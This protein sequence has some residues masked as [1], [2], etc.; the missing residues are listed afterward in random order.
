MTKGEKQ[1]ASIAVCD[2]WTMNMIYLQARRHERLLA[3]EKEESLYRSNDRVENITEKRRAFEYYNKV[4]KRL[5]YEV[6]DLDTDRDELLKGIRFEQ[7][8]NTANGGNNRRQRDVTAICYMIRDYLKERLGYDMGEILINAKI[9]EDR[10]YTCDI[11]FEKFRLA[12]EVN[13]TS[14]KGR[15]EYDNEKDQAYRKNGYEVIRITP[16]RYGYPVNAT[17]FVDVP[18]RLPNG[19]NG[20]KSV[21]IISVI[22]D[23]LNK[24]RQLPLNGAYHI[25]KQLYEESKRKIEY[26]NISYFLTYEERVDLYRHDDVV[27]KSNM[28]EVVH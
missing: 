16:L 19:L 5:N 11:V 25:A 14:H 17:R 20:D 28:K 10:K 23:V 18:E 4:L 26:R 27:N 12:I 21:E 8:V 1:N 15:I 6:T 22:L 9:V 7:K 2:C 24:S 3:K 13:G